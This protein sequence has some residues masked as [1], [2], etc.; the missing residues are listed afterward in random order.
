MRRDRRYAAG[1]TLVEVLL[2]IVIL[3]V[4]AG[5]VVFAVGNTSANSRTQAC[6]TEAHE[7][8]SAYNAYAANHHGANV[9]GA[10]T[11]AMAGNLKADGVLAKSQLSYLSS[12]QG[13]PINPGGWQ[14][15]ANGT[16]DVTG[17]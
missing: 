2:V 14:Y 6:A 7:F 16:V 10:N 17:C 5:I 12:T 13:G 9:S 8:V 11:Q 15:N 4:L 3:G 1:F